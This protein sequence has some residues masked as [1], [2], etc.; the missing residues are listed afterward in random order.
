[1]LLEVKL[2]TLHKCVDISLNKN[3]VVGDTSASNFG[4]RLGIPL[5]R[6]L[7]EQDFIKVGDFLI[8][9]V[10]LSKL[11]QKRSGKKLVYFKK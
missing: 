11:I 6:G 5:T 7:K 4:I 3:S 10:E 1:M 8:E 9:V 2:N